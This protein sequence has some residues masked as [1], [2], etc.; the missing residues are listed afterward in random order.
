MFGTDRRVVVLALA[1]MADAVA[2]SF[3]II[4]LPLYIASGELA[5][6]AFEGA[7]VLGIPLTVELLIG[8]ALSLFGFVNSFA[9]PFTGRL[10]DRTARRKIYILFGLVVLAVTSV[11]YALVES[12]E[13]L[14]VVR[15]LQGLGGAFVIPTTIA[16]V[17]DLARSDAERGGNFGVF[18]TFRLIGFGFGPIVAG[19]VVQAGPYALPLGTELSGFNAAFGVAVLGALV[20]FTLVTVLI[21]E[22]PMAAAD[23]T[24]DLSIAVFGDSR[25]L[26]PVFVLGVATF[27]MAVSIAL[28][29]TL[30]E[31][32]N[33]R[34]SQG[35][36]WFG[37]QF[38]A[39]VVANVILQMPI[40]RA[41]DRIGRRPFLVWGLVLLV[42]A[43]LAQGL[44]TS[45]WTM[46]V[47]R[48]LHGVSVAMVFAPALAVA[49]D[50]AE[51]GESGTTLSV[52]TMAFGLGTAVGPL[53][54][55]V[56]F[57]YAFVVPFAAGAV[58][59]FLALVLVATQVEETLETATGG[60]ILG[61]R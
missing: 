26:D 29:A 44:V 30:Q 35:P 25:L 59:A 13:A 45:S 24:D 34:L 52:L 14:L 4:V 16:L 51:E 47:V 2:N 1:R 5:L 32:I 55:G 11:A 58:L 17:N 22:P 33:D 9:Q 10:S 15:A 57:G 36:L 42:P 54:S 8:V 18:N 20:S 46:L 28:F 23:A 60:P 49:G 39:V 31:P 61:G 43:V 40:G 3:L 38:A 48:L 27:F 12:Y 7:S 50:L 37:I 53:S 21:E 41:A 19:V 56:L 6:P